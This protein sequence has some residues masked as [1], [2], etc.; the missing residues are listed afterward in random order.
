MV[1]STAKRGFRQ[2]WA[3]ADRAPQPGE[4]EFDSLDLFGPQE[5]EYVEPGDSQSIV[6]SPSEPLQSTLGDAGQLES[7]DVRRCLISMS[8]HPTDCKHKIL[9]KNPIAIKVNQNKMKK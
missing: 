8:L 2:R 1:D 9:P 3:S 4:A 7:E 5:S 6:P